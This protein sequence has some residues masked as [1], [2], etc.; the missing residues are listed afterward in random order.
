MGS[1]GDEAPVEIHHAKE[2]LH[3]LDCSWLWELLD[4]LH[5]G[6]EREST[7]SGHY[8]AQEL[9][10]WHIECALFQVNDQPKLAQP[11]EE[12][13]EVVDVLLG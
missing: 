3:L 4:S 2:H 6:L 9:N 11:L 12:D 1:V 5:V 10:L 7:T 8:V 13:E